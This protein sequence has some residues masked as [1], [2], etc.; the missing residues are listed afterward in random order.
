[1]ETVGLS[2]NWQVVLLPTYSE[3]SFGNSVGYPPN[4]CSK[5]GL[6]LEVTCTNRPDRLACL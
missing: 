1:M 4:H 2:V 6:L 3:S 5:V